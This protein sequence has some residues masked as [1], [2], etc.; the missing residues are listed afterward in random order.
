VSDE[1]ASHKLYWTDERIIG[2]E[3]PVELGKNNSGRGVGGSMIHYAGYWPRFHPS[4][5]GVRTRD[6]VGEDWPIA[7]WDLKPHYER[8]QLELP[9]S[10]ERWPWGDPHRYAHVPHPIAGGAEITRSGARKLGIEVRVGP[11]G[12][13]ALVEFNSSRGVSIE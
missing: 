10:G 11:V 5:F 2:G 9:V 12:I 6:G 8:L 4:D 7:Y 13:T 3:D 1:A